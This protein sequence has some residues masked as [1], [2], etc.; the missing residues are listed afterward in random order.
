MTALQTPKGFIQSILPQNGTSQSFQPLLPFTSGPHR[1]NQ[2]PERWRKVQKMALRNQKLP[3]PT[4]LPATPPHEET[5]SASA[6]N[7]ASIPAP[8]SRSRSNSPCGWLPKPRGLKNVQ[9]C[10]KTGSAQKKGAPRRGLLQSR[11]TLTPTAINTGNDRS[12][13]APQ[14]ARQYTSPARRRAS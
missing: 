2:G 4:C 9:K 7:A 5:I 8:R 6:T 14:P 10:S 3:K 13:T 12:Y 11:K 1:S